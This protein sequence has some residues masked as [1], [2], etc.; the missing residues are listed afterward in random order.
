[1]LVVLILAVLVILSPGFVWFWDGDFENRIESERRDAVEQEMQEIFDPEKD[2]L[3]RV[4]LCSAAR[5]WEE[6]QL[7]P[8]VARWLDSEY[9]PIDLA[10]DC[11]YQQ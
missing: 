10:D 5:L 3:Y 1:M 9:T 2:Y 4:F 8:V 7:P 11:F 6:D